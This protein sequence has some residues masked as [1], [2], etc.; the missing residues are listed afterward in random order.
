LTVLVAVMGVLIVV[1]VGVLVTTIAR[2]MSP[3]VAPIGRLEV[4]IG[5]D[6]KLIGARADGDRLVLQLEQAGVPRVLVI[7]LASG[8]ITGDVRLVVSP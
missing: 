4:P 7:D 5:A 6:T 8:A 3:G 2:R 1:G